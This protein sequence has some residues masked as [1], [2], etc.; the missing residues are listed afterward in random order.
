MFRYNFV[1]QIMKSDIHYGAR[2]IQFMD[3]THLEGN[4]AIKICANSII[5]EIFYID[6]YLIC[7]IDKSR[8]IFKKK[9]NSIS[10]FE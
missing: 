6:T 5:L 10:S 9:Y 8:N 1:F 3:I 4:S 7:E 2:L